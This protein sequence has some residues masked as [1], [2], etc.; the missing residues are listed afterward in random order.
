MRRGHGFLPR[1]VGQ[2]NARAPFYELEWRAVGIATSAK[3][4]HRRRERSAGT[5]SRS[6]GRPR[7]AHA[8]SFRAYTDHAARQSAATQMLLRLYGHRRM[9]FVPE[10]KRRN[11]A[12]LLIRRSPSGVRSSNR[13]RRPPFA[14]ATAGSFD[15]RIF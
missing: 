3:A 8:E 12:A 13:A 6:H 9:R 1:N 7:H 10:R 14:W 15:A 5:R 2:T 4:R 11:I